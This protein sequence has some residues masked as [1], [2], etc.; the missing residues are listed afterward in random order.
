MKM[1]KCKQILVIGL[2]SFSVS[3]FAQSS[4]RPDVHVGDRWAWLHS[5]GL[6]KETDHTQI[7][8]VVDVKDNEI[9]TRVRVKG[10]QGSA[11]AAYSMD[12]NPIDVVSARYDP[13]LKEF[14][15]PL[16]VGKKWDGEADKMLFSN[17]KH[18]KFILKAEV[19]ALEKITVPAGTFDAY[20]ID[21]SIDAAS[22]DENANI[23]HTAETI[24]FAPSVRRYVKSEYTFTRDGRVRSKD[25]L[26]LLEFSLR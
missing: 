4:E 2:L 14:D 11:I 9:T 10:Q 26:E 23:G 22:T 6:V 1:V 12:W 5:N 8:D 17:G 13:L 19:T 7:E 3:S 25:I 24:W 20:R 15:F 16:Q 21:I 18:G